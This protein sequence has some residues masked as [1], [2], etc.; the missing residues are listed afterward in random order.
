MIIS[1][2][3]IKFEFCP[4]HVQQIRSSVIFITKISPFFDLNRVAISWFLREKKDFLSFFMFVV[5]WYNGDGEIKVKYV[6]LTESVQNKYF[7]YHTYHDND[8]VYS[9]ANTKE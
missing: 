2:I 9:V 7:C 6:F 5:I 8:N 3:I 4:K 1:R